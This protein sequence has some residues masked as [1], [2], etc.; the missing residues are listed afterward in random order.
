M[1]QDP[2]FAFRIIVD[3]ATKALSPAVNDPTTAVLAIDQLHHLLRDVGNRSLAEGQE[4]D[5]AG[6]IRVIYRTPDWED[7]V[8]LAITEVRQ[9]GSTSIQ[10]MRRLRAMLENLIATLPAHR[11][12]L[13]SRELMMLERSARRSFPEVDDQELAEASDLQGMGAGDDSPYNGPGSTHPPKPSAPV[14]V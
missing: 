14:N 4:K 3:V 2:M 10:V 13:L 11:T 7:F 1:E 9:Y 12:P 6:K 8:R 5:P